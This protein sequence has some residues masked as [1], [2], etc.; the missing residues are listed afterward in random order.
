MSKLLLIDAG[1]TRVKWLLV[2]CAL[3]EPLRYTVI[4]SGDALT[5]ELMSKIG[6]AT[7]A[8]KI[9]ELALLAGVDKFLLASV[10]GPTWE[11]EFKE[12]ICPLSVICPKPNES[13]HLISRYQNPMQLG[14]DRWLACLAAAWQTATPLNLIV[15]L[16][17]A[18]TIDGVISGSLASP[19]AAQCFVH[20][21]G[22]IVP[23]VHTMLASLNQS[24]QQLPLVEP[25]QNDWPTD[26]EQAI[27][28]GV[29]AAQ[30][31]LITSKAELLEKDFPG[32]ALTIWLG[33][34]YSEQ[35]QLPS[36]WKTEHAKSL[37]FEGLMR[38]QKAI[39]S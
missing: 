18:T 34:G 20:L 2:D 31:A 29:L 36:K 28:A 30:I 26:T 17:T 21:G 11:Q 14:V 19:K 3:I 9:A 12:A 7:F 8:S 10:L 35:V 37:V 33:G 1:N 13:D 5:V 27:G 24:T 25:V 16:G 39:D 6:L 38:S 32:Q 22:V 4:E 23:G 15:S